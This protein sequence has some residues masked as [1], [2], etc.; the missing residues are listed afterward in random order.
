M[1]EAA[2][3]RTLQEARTTKDARMRNILCLVAALAL[4]ATSAFGQADVEPGRYATGSARALGG[5]KLP[6]IVDVGD[7]SPEGVAIAKA[8][9]KAMARSRTV[10]ADYSDDRRKSPIDDRA[11]VL[12][13][14]VTV[15][16]DASGES[17]T[18]KIELRFRGDVETH[19]VACPSDKPATCARHIAAAAEKF[20]VANNAR[21][22]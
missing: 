2:R 3:R 12:V 16:R 9:R 7:S 17:M 5:P 1:A 10:S 6:I 14:P 13:A 18:V 20:V 4:V 22:R 11:A 15:T 19:D 8:V 21:P